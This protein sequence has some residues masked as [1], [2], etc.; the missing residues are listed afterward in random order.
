MGKNHFQRDSVKGIVGLLVIH[1]YAQPRSAQWVAHLNLAQYQHAYI[2]SHVTPGLAIAIVHLL[3][4]F[5]GIEVY[6]HAIPS[7]FFLPQ[8][9]SEVFMPLY[10]QRFMK[11]SFYI[12]FIA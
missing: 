9:Q 1:V 7:G 4:S 12:T 10:A 8:S 11:V 6:N 5:I 3:Q 2:F